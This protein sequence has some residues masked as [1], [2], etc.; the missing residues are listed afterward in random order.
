MLYFPYS[1]YKVNYSRYMGLKSDGFMNFFAYKKVLL[2][3]KKKTVFFFCCE[4]IYNH[5][6]YTTKLNELQM[7]LKHFF[8]FL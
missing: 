1:G 2:K 4:K 3:N 7:V 5:P 8:D 6:Y